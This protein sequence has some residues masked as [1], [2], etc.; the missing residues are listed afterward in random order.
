MS[1]GDKY[2]GAILTPDEFEKFEAARINQKP[3]RAAGSRD[4]L[5]DYFCLDEFE[6]LVN[7]TG[8]WT[9][10]R[11][12]VMLDSQKVPPQ[13]L[14][15]QQQLHNGKKIRLEAANLQKLLDR[16]ASVILND[17]DDMADGLK[18]LKKIIAGYTG[19]KV[20][21]NLYYS[22]PGHQAFS[23]HFDVHDVFAFQIAGK[24]RWKVYQQA[25]RFPINHLAFLG[26]DPAKHEKAKGPVS[27]DFLMEEGDFVYIPAGYY[28]E[29]I[30]IDSISTHLSF[31]TV[32]MIGLDVISELFNTGILDE[33]FRSPIRRT[34]GS[35]MPVAD[36]LKFLTENLAR[37]MSS[38]AFTQ[39]I[40]KKLQ[41]FP[42]SAGNISIKK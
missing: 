10:D 39:A 23:V 27:M 41:S 9:P 20:E 13:N 2:L 30:C 4:R 7:Q 34:G 32:E 22:Q 24:K 8:I 36:Y 17:I 33:F 19:A 16:G 25:H 35:N 29:A 26:G 40:E 1:Q 5:S 14:Y 31:G 12:E 6:R 28:H 18:S 21:S 38:D 37:L 3:F 42:H 11:L 15:S